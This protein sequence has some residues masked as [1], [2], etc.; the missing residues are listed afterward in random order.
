MIRIA[1]V[2]AG[3]RSLGRATFLGSGLEFLLRTVKAVRRWNRRR[4]TRRTLE[5]LDDR[6][7]ADIGLSR[8]DVIAMRVTHAQ[9]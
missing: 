2:D 7:L 9:R 5:E 4:R 6:M 3:G 1:T 8:T